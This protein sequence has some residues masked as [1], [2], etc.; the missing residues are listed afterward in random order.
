MTSPRDI[1]NE[2]RWKNNFNL[3]NVLIFYNH[4]GAVDDT[5]SISGNDVV[6]IERSF[7]QTTSA[8]IPYHRI[9]KITFN[10]E[11]IFERKK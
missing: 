8:M 10:N 3:D 4:R 6:K 5:K 11:V 2:I 9:F 7:M 1:L